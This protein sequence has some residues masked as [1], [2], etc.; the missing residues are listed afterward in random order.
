MATA[1]I[2]DEHDEALEDQSRNRKTWDKVHERAMRR[3]DAAVGPQLEQRAISLQARRFVSIPGAQWEGDW[4][5][6]FD[7]S[8]KLEINKT[9]RGLEKIYRDYNENR[10]VPD[11]RPAGSK[12]DDETANT[13][14]GVF[15]ADAYYFKS[16]QALDNAFMEAG[17][18]G[19]GAW[20]LTTEWADPYDKDS[21]EQRINPALIIADADQRVFF[22]P[23]SLLYDKSDAKF[24]FVITA[25]STPEFEEEHEGA[26]TSWETNELE[27][28]YDWF[29]PDVVKVA[30]YYEVEDID[31]DVLIFTHKLSKVEQRYW[32]S[33]VAPSEITDLRKMGWSI[34]TR[35][36]KR[37]RVHK[38]VLT[39]AEVLKD[40]GY[41]AGDCIPV[42]PV[43]GKR[44]FVD[45]IERF[46]GYVQDK[47]DAQR[48]YNSNVSRLAE[49]NA[50]SPREIPIFASEQMPQHLKD[51]WAKQ[52]IDRHAYALVDPL[53]NPDGTI[54]AAGPIGKIEPPQVAPVQAA[55][56]QIANN[57]LLEEQ[58]DGSDT[59]KANVSAEAL[60]VAA[61]RVDARSGIYLDNMRQ[62]VMRGGEVYLSM[63]ADIYIEPD[64][65][66][67]TMTEE[68]DDG[69][70]TL[71]EQYTGPAGE[72]GTRNDFSRGHYKVIVEVT[73]ATATRRDKTVK[74]C[75]TLTEMMAHLDPEL[76]QAA[77][78][79]AVSNMDGEGMADLQ[80][81]ARKKALMSGLAE[82]TEEEK[83]QMD[84]A[85]Q[86]E[87]QQPDPQAD[88]VAAKTQESLAAAGQKKA[89]ALLKVAQATK[90]GGPEQAPEV[91][92]GL[93]AAHKLIQ[94]RKDAAD[95]QHMETQTAHL[96]QK[97]AIE[98]TNAQTNRLK[99]LQGRDRGAIQ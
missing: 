11:F 87:Q 24:A 66:V 22:D 59:V 75:L 51:L 1:P 52:I 6:P 53:R 29:T 47:M 58:Q 85:A 67:E 81:F 5:D 30:E 97:M 36:A 7:N 39:G 10:I 74:S 84:A 46:S 61:T 69:E 99:A 48:L 89:D 49:T 13:L 18:G 8:I 55:L 70:A 98:E 34:R 78:I 25:K 82:P 21:D 23:D 73:E 93:E 38:Y 50:Q 79:T 65:K 56:L 83:Q 35:T 12:G 16:Q 95:A 41:L 92:S 44:W 90:L 76:A 63:C 60:E 3:F 57:D 17:A 86:N 9:G 27:P 68:G 28:L 14:D 4:A 77:A 54:A 19:F 45:G 15:R 72:T 96:P 33:E 62:S 88:L 91:P 80:K 20:R 37:R 43:Y 26:I 94:I 31:D 40:Q 2:A 71:L 64:R 42:V 32:R